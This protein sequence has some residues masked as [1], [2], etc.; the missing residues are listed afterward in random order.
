MVAELPVH[1]GDGG[2]A[3]GQATLVHAFVGTGAP[4]EHS[5][6]GDGGLAERPSRVRPL[7]RTVGRAGTGVPAR[8]GLVGKFVEEWYVG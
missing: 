2:L 6:G 3:G 4:T 8:D 7:A 5:D 1:D